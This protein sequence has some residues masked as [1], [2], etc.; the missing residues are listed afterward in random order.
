[1][2]TTTTRPPLILTGDPRFRAIG[3]F[4]ADSGDPLNVFTVDAG[5]LANDTRHYPR[6]VER[7]A[8]RWWKEF[9]PRGHRPSFGALSSWAADE[10]S[11]GRRSAAFA[12]LDR[13]AEKGRVRRAGPHSV[14]YLERF[15]IRT[16]YATG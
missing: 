2:L 1:V 11:L 7:D 14:T 8:A 13:L 4:D 10:C 5:R 6:R 15:L 3:G 9:E 16:G 12:T